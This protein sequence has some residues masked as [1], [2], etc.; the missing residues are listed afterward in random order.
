MAE[1]TRVIESPPLAHLFGADALAEVDVSAILPGPQ[2]QRMRGTIDR[3]VITP[4]RVLIVDFK[5]NRVVP[6][7]AASTPIGILRQMAAYFVAIEAIYPNRKIDLAIV[8]THSAALMP[9]PHVIVRASLQSLPH[10]DVAA[11]PS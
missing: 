11:V 1:V 8:W 9:L 7:D 5:S 4:G 10:L 2:F 6:A 3:L